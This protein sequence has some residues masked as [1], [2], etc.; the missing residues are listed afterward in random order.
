MLVVAEKRR[1]GFEPHGVSLSFPA[2]SLQP[3][4]IGKR[5]KSAMQQGSFICKSS[6]TTIYQRLSSPSFAVGTTI[7]SGNPFVGIL[8]R[9]VGD[10]HCER[11]PRMWRC[12]STWPSRQSNRPAGSGAVEY[13]P[14]QPVA[15]VRHNDKLDRR[16]WLWRAWGLVPSWPMI[17]QS[18]IG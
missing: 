13:R 17:R 18:A 1:Q 9:C 2:W 5:G 4:P 3:L 7:E 6:I 10:L 12:C 16:G 15:I 14:T 11:Q 8:A